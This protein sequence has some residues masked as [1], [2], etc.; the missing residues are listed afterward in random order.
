MCFEAITR[1]FFPEPARHADSPALAIVAASDAWTPHALA[2]H[3]HHAARRLLAVSLGRPVL[4]TTLAGPLLHMDAGGNMVAF[5]AAGAQPASL[6][7]SPQATPASVYARWAPFET[8]G[9]WW[10]LLI[11]A[12]LRC[13]AGGR[14]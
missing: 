11:M 12:V 13:R 14:S 7:V 9:V 2:S 3:A 1:S 5:T 6:K 8:A 4:V 10:L